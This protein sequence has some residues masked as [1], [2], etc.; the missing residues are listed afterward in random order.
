MRSSSESPS[1]SEIVRMRAWFRRHYV[2]FRPGWGKDKTP[3]YVA[4]QLWFGWDGWRWAEVIVAKERGEPHPQDV[5]QWI[6]TVR[7]R[8]R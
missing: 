6:A 2:D 8:D 3:G 7:K 4:N 1:R 5:L